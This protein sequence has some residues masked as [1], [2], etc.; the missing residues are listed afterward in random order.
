MRLY[1]R[2][3]TR[4]PKTIFHTG[5]LPKRGYCSSKNDWYLT[6][7]QNKFEYSLSPKTSASDANMEQVVCLSKKLESTPLFP[8]CDLY[9][10]DYNSEIYIYVMALPDEKYP[11]KNSTEEVHVFNLQKHQAE[12]VKTI[13]RSSNLSVNPAMAGYVLS[14]HEVFSQQVATQNIIC[15]VKCKRSD[16]AITTE[17]PVFVRHKDDADPFTLIQAR[18]FK[19]EH[20]IFINTQYTQD[21][22]HKTHAIKELRDKQRLGMQ[23]TS[24][25]QDALNECGIEYDSNK[26][27]TSTYLWQ[28]LI[29]FQFGMAFFSILETIYYTA[30]H[31]GKYCMNNEIEEKPTKIVEK[32]PNEMLDTNNKKS[33][34]FYGRYFT[35]IGV[36]T[37]EADPID[38][39]QI[40]RASRT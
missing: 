34:S 20:E 23:P 29:S 11:Q 8:I 36:L 9:H 14:G 5:F 16:I 39:Y 18:Q 33:L 1:Y 13:L 19:L 40:K 28:A 22:K 7:I 35:T 37:G 3:D 21:E 25:V 38:A 6:G 10:T 24:N 27:H 31:L 15:A 30:I 2:A 32:L 17:S 12:E 4:N 26:I